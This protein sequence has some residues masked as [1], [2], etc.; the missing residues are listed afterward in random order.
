MES[1]TSF[2]QDLVSLGLDSA[3]NEIAPASIGEVANFFR[4]LAETTSKTYPQE[5]T[6]SQPIFD[7]IVTF[8]TQEDWQFQQIKGEPVLRLAFQ[9]KNG[10]WTC[11]AKAREQQQQFVFYSVCP[12]SIPENK[13]QAM[14][15][16]VA[17]AKYGTIIGNF[18]LDFV[19]GEIRYKTSID[20]EGSTLTF[21]QSKQLVYTNVMMMARSLYKRVPDEQK[22]PVAVARR[23]GIGAPWKQ[24]C[25][26]R[27]RWKSSGCNSAYECTLRT[28]VAPAPQAQG[29]AG[30]E[31]RGTRFRRRPSCPRA[32]VRA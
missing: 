32:L 24:R 30:P 25:D 10:K 5:T 11:Y 3:T 9:G 26:R 22:S 27:G 31:W 7:E 12:V 2:F 29:R 18:E 20:V 17:R 6:L 13:L 16:F 21:P 23:P 8:F 28:H 15:E 14:A 1:I 4:D 19:S